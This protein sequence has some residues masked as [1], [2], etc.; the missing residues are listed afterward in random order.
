MK[1][2][3][4][5]LFIILALIIGYLF[6]SLSWGV[7]IG[8]VFYHKDIRKE[9]SGNAGGTNAGRVLGKK[10]GLIVIVLDILKCILSVWITYF[11]FKYALKN[12]DVFLNNTYYAYIAGLGTCIGHTFPLF[13]SFKGGKA[14][15]CYAG[16]VIA[17]NWGLA[18]GGFIL[19]MIILFISKYVSLTSIITTLVVGIVSFIP[20]FSYTMCF[21]LQYDYVLGIFL[22]GLAIYILIRHRSNIIR[23]KNHQEKKI[24]WLK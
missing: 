14:V 20:I 2:L 6:G 8:K 11:L 5:I 9:G 13:A 16:L 22:L 7:F 10:V 19:Y 3:L 24:T 15:A 1:I 17:L 4:S 23:L 21:S 12:I 18:I